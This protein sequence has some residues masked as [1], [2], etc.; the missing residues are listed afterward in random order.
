MV[1]FGIREKC[2]GSL[3]TYHVDSLYRFRRTVIDEVKTDIF[4]LKQE[5]HTKENN[6]K[7][8]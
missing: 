6:T 7:I 3:K 2:L 4:I 1:K 5:Y 8:Q